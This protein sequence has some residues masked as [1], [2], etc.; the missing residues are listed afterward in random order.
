MGLWEVLS[1]SFQ[2][3]MLK[4]YNMG[5][6]EDTKKLLYRKSNKQLEQAEQIKVFDWKRTNEKQYPAL[7]LLHSIPNGTYSHIY[8]AIITKRMGILSGMPDICLPINPIPETHN[9]LYIE[10]KHGKN[11]LSKSQKSIKKLLE[12]AGNKV[13][14]CYSSEEAI[15]E[16]K[17]YL[18]M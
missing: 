5:F 9:A 16:I 18:A 8:T 11:K 13:V 17:N 15:N 6:E 4:G 10:M 14:V 1:H 7:K 12:G 3:N 2:A